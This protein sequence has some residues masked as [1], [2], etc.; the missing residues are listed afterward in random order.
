MFSSFVDLIMNSPITQF[1]DDQ[2]PFFKVKT[3]LF[4][5]VVIE[6]NA[7]TSLPTLV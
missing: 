6:M 2:S 3:G 4:D 7:N 1:V 5:T